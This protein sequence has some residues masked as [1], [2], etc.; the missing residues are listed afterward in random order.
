MKGLLAPVFVVPEVLIVMPE[1]ALFRVAAIVQTPL[2]KELVVGLIVPVE[3]DRLFV[4]VYPVMTSLLKSTAV[5]VMLK[6]APATW[7]P[8]GLKLK[9]SSGPVTLKALLVPDFPL[10]DVEMVSVG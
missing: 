9:W 2:L 8:T 3:T 1:P 6:G 10:P 4:S 7:L 5:M